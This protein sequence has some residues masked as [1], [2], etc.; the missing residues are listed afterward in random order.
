VPS[1]TRPWHLGFA[2]SPCPALFLRQIQRTGMPPT[3]DAFAV[4]RRRWPASARDDTRDASLLPTTDVPSLRVAAPDLA[5]PWRGAS[6]V[7]N[8]AKF[9]FCNI[10]V[11]QHCCNAFFLCKRAPLRWPGAG[12]QSDVAAPQALAL[13]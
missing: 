4:L 13:G 6:P 10:L 9:S 7:E 12:V 3:L 1:A 8:I 5:R 11:H 2:S